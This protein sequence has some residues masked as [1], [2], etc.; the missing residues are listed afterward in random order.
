[1]RHTSKQENNNRG[2]SMKFNYHSTAGLC[3]ICW[4]TGMAWAKVGDMP[5][6]STGVYQWWLPATMFLMLIIPFTAGYMAGKEVK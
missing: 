6:P 2:G 4:V 5:T 3:Y 1:M